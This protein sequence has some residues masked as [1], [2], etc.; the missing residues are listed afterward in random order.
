[1][2]LNEPSPASPQQKLSLW[3][4]TSIIVGIIIGASIYESTPLIAGCAPNLAWLVAIWTFGAVLMVVGALCYAELANAYPR[5][6]GDY[7]YLTEAF[8][9]RVGFIFGWMQFWVVRP[10]SIAAIAFV[11]A[12]YANEL[13]PISE[14]SHGL[15]VHA[16]LS[17][18]GLSGVN[19]LGVQFGKHTQNLLTALKYI[20]L[21]AVVLRWAESPAANRSQYRVS[22]PRRKSSPELAICHDSRTFCLRRLARNRLCCDRS[23]LTA[24]ECIEGAIARLIPCGC[25]LLAGCDLV[26]ACTRAR[27][28][29][30]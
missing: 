13:I 5:H 28:S 30:Q 9:L 23:P 10:G 20:G 7:A 18:I 3:D 8:G 25:N 24:K 2:S 27:W 17:I 14:R 4:A 16:A 29:P 26:R 11:F 21:V 1:M 15:M 19:L 22:D 6:G 12:R